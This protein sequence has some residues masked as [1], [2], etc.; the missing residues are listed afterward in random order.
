[1]DGPSR[2]RLKRPQERWILRSGF[3]RALGG[4]PNN[5]SRRPDNLINLINQSGGDKSGGGHEG[6]EYGHD[7]RLQCTDA[8][9]TDGK[10]CTQP[11]MVAFIEPS[12]CKVA[13]IGNDLADSK[14]AREKKKKTFDSDQPPFLAMP[15]LDTLLPE[16]TEAS[17]RFGHPPP[18]RSNL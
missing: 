6:E 11:A 4:R 14:C 7:P 17:D 9:S 2:K 8:G 13:S 12:Y 3:S 15:P 1:M 18:G 16:A 10:A 5:D